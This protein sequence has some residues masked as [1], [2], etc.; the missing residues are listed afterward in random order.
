MTV[1]S[2]ADRALIFTV[3]KPGADP[4]PPPNI[5][6]ITP[7]PWTNLSGSFSTFTTNA[8]PG[9]SIPALK[10]VGY[11][12]F[13]NANPLL[14]QGFTTLNF[15]GANQ[16]PAPAADV[17][18][19]W[20]LGPTSLVWQSNQTADPGFCPQ[21]TPCTLAAFAAH[22]PN[23]AWG[24][25]QVGLGAGVGPTT[26]YV[27]NVQ[28]SDGTSTFTYDFEPASIP[29][30]SP[31]SPTPTFHGYWLAATDG[32]VFNF[33]AAPFHG[34]MGGTIL[35]SPV[36]GMA[37]TPA[38]GY[39]LGASDGGVFSFGAPFLGSMGGKHLNS[40]IVGIAGTPDGGGYYLVASDG[41]VFTFGDAH[42][43]GSMGGKPLNKPIVGI[44]V[45]PGNLGYYLV[46]SDGGVFTFGD[47]Q[48]QGSMGGQ[49]LN[50]PV[51][52]M[53]VD[54]ATSGYWLVA[55]DGGVFSFNALFLG[56]TG[57]LHLNAPVV[58]MAATATGLGYRFV[59]SDGG[60][61]C[62]GDAPFVGS[63]GGKHLNAPIVAMSSTD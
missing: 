11:Q 33:G 36:I 25:I 60:V 15:E 20:T 26:S 42:F 46:A 54:V 21:S 5:G 7:T 40:P 6:A 41:G 34:S 28:I 43:D 35:N 23:G 19:T 57:S 56:S 22:Y 13:N 2:T 31:S 24:Q 44:A 14:S 63:M 27:D 52:G 17:W 29:S 53:A 4:T 61:F 39:W 12:Q 30:T 45:T 47:A 62:F 10:I 37:G 49:P 32:G 8:N 38:G 1:A 51:V 3:P 18:Q 16:T 58:G 9:P 48:F 59:A 50:K 55:Q